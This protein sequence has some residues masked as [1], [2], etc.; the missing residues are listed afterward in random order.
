M[1]ESEIRERWDAGDMVAALTRVLQSYGVELQ[2][3]LFATTAGPTEAHDIYCIVAED[4]WKGL[5]SFQ[6]RCSV[7]AWAYT[8]ARHAR[9]RYVIAERRR[10][11]RQDTL[12]TAPWLRD[13][14]ERTR[15]PTPMHE[16]SEVVH[17]LRSLR[18]GLD[19]LDRTLL[20]LRIDRGLSWKELAVVLDQVGPDEDPSTAA[21][22]LRQRF[23]VVKKRLRDM[24]ERAGLIEQ[25]HDGV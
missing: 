12:A 5:P 9:A 14:V 25:E 24:A 18:D 6:W 19:E 3:Y 2:R 7:R 15:T 21:A 20:M 11:V 10:M 13:L 17:G 1:V 4:L 23:Q 8:L 16:R 22:R